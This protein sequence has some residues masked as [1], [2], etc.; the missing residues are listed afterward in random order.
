VA[1]LYDGIEQAAFRKIEGGYI[2]YCASPWLFG[3]RRG[4][5]VDAEQKQAIAQCLRETLR[6]LKP[7]VLIAA[8]LI[9]LALLGGTFWL[10]FRGATLTI[11]TTDDQGRSI[12]V[13]QPIGADGSSGSFAGLNGARIDF[14]VSG[15]PSESSAL[16]Y[17]WISPKGEVGPPRF[18]ALKPGGAR[19]NLADES[20]RVVRS[21]VLSGRKGATQNAIFLDAMLLGLATFGPY[22]I[23][24]RLYTRRRLAPL[25]AGLPRSTQRLSPRERSEA[26]AAAASVKL[27]AVMAVG[28]AAAWLGAV[29]S[30][31]PPLL[32]RGAISASPSV[33]L[34]PVAAILTTVPLARAILLRS[35]LRCAAASAA[36]R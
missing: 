9:P 18:M 7:F 11:L 33:F 23:A 10:A 1:G 31:L 8:V 28:C 13:S 3:R 6:R 17:V 34:C 4:Y 27:L 24:I 15:P 2:F 19:I 30:I 29:M 26:F 22:F 21:V 32:E 16:R 14:H 20:G 5:L 36:A 35:R 12:S 25:I